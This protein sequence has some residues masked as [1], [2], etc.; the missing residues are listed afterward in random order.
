MAAT[1][2]LARQERILRERVQS[3][4][5]DLY[6]VE[7][8]TLGPGLETKPGDWMIVGWWED[9]PDAPDAKQVVVSVGSFDKVNL[10]LDVRASEELRDDTS[11]DLNAT[12]QDAYEAFMRCEAEKEAI[13][14]KVN[15][16]WLKRQED[17][18]RAFESR[19][20]M[21]GVRVM[22]ENVFATYQAE[23]TN[24]PDG[25]RRVLQGTRNDLDKWLTGIEAKR[26]A[27]APAPSEARKASKAMPFGNLMALIDRDGFDRP[28]GEREQRRVR[29]YER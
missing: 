6:Q 13:Y 3:I 5:G 10:Y 2:E 26:P 28:R 8:A 24:A 14:A 11:A 27:V 18:L 19:G 15:P 4:C 22:R 7:P 25:N 23:T 20:A 1:E 17:E 21:V 12:P 9:D 29:D 16:A